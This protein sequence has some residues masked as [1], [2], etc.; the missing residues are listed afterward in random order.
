MS[1]GINENSGGGQGG[2]VGEIGSA[3]L[4]DEQ[5]YI[6]VMGGYGR[7]AERPGVVENSK[8]ARQP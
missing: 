8:N 2:V 7:R 5:P 6:E 1:R 3:L 4:L